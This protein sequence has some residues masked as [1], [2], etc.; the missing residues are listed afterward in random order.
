VTAQQVS[1]G[2]L[3]AANVMTFVEIYSARASAWQDALVVRFSDL[4][5]K[6]EGLR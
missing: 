5:V 3:S 1:L 4:D 2:Y 6:L